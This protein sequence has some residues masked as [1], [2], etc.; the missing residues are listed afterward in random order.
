MNARRTVALLIAALAAYFVLIGYRGFYLLGQHKVSLKVLG[1]AVLVLPL[2]G[3]W[4][5]VAE[6]RFGFATQRLAAV[7]DEEGVEIDEPE[8]ARHPSG[9]VDR[10]AA[11]AYFERRRTIVEADPENWRGWYQ[12]AVAY[13]L[14]GDRRRAR[15]AMRRAIAFA[16]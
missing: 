3:L 16:A 15:E 6:V 5:V 13:D 14:A 2:V 9:R 1:V 7:L 10:K 8:L 4:V 11:D 12:L